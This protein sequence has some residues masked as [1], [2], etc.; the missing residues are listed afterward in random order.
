MASKIKIHKEGLPVGIAVIA[1]SAVK[2]NPLRFYGIAVIRQVHMADLF[3]L[4]GI[5]HAQCRRNLLVESLGGVD[6]TAVAAGAL[7]GFLS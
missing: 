7:L 1:L 4:C 5:D 2:L 6:Q 3:L